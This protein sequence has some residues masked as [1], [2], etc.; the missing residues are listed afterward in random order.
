MQGGLTRDKTSK[1][2]LIR[3]LAD[4]V[5]VIKLKQTL[6]LLVSLYTAFIVGG[7]LNKSLYYHIAVLLIGFASI[8]AVTAMNMY[9][10]MDIDLLMERTRERPLPAGRLNP[11]ATLVLSTLAL[12]ASLY[13]GFKLVNPYF[14]LGIFIGFVFYIIAYTLLLK[15]RTPL[16]IIAGAVAGG[17]PAMGG[18]AA[19]TGQID[20]NALLFSLIVIAW[21]P[22]HIWSLATYY[23]DDYRRANVPMLPAV[24]GDPHGIAAGIGLGALVIGYAVAGLA[25]T[26]AIGPLSLVIGLAFAAYVFIQAMNYSSKGGDPVFARKMFVRVNMGLAFLF[27][28]MIVEKL[29]AGV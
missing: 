16:N 20:V 21:I 14:A 25:V 2:R 19:A 5:E 12:A 23:K 27:L 17:A 8:S 9:F 3:L 28:T 4:I 18:W 24:S 26:H 1:T 10:D 6:L 22:A 15:R 11:H 7:G 13:Y 29:L